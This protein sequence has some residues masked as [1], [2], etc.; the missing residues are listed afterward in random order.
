MSA[1]PAAPLTGDFQQVEIFIPLNV[2]HFAAVQGRLDRAI[3][4]GV[5]LEVVND[6]GADGER[7]HHVEKVAS[8]AIGKAQHR[9]DF[10]FFQEGDDFRV[11]F[12]LQA[13]P[14]KRQQGTDN[15]H[16]SGPVRNDPRPFVGDFFEQMDLVQ[17]V[18]LR[19]RIK[20]V[21]V[22]GDVDTGHVE[23]QEH[24]DRAGQRDTKIHP[25]KAGSGLHAQS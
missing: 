17:R 25:V 21:I 3:H 13:R 14:E 16:F 6:P 24:R 4:A 1:R 9:C 18:R 22:E 15:R 2:L 23:H 19:H 8:M 11:L 20:K 5:A 12:S 10:D 7:E